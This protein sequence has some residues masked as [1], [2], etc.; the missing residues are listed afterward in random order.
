MNEELKLNEWFEVGRAG[1]P[2][3]VTAPDG[4]RTERKAAVIY[5]RVIG[6]GVFQNAFD[7][8]LFPFDSQTLIIK[9][10]SDW[11]VRDV[12]LVR[13]MKHAYKSLGACA[14]WHVMP[15]MC[16]RRDALWLTRAAR[17]Q[18]KMTHLC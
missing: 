18:C 8:R 5:W 2:V 13:N 15:R 12:R 10:L 14:C 11:D 6:C 3:E 7:I 1:C 16:G 4:T 17:V 9:L